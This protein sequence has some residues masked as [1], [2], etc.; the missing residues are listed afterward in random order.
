[1]NRRD[2]IRANRYP[3]FLA[4][5]DRNVPWS[6]KQWTAPPHGPPPAAGGGPSAKKNR[7]PR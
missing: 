4:S 7:K 1:M 3:E 5:A 6:K 2:F